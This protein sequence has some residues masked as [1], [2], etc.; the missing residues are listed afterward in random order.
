MKSALGLDEVQSL[1]WR[2][3]TA[4]AGVASGVAALQEEGALASEGLGW[5]VRP[6]ATLSPT[7][8]LDIYADMYFYRL[9]DCLAED[10]PTLAKWLGPARFHNLV[11]DYLLVHPSRH[12]SLRELGRE[13]PGF[14]ESR[15]LAPP[16]RAASDLAALEWARVDVF[17]ETDAEPLARQDLIERATAS[18]EH[19]RLAL[20][21][22]VRLIRLESA[23]LKLWR[24][25]ED[26]GELPAVG[27]TATGDPIPVCVWRRDFALC[28]RSLEPDEARCLGALAGEPLS[29]AAL[30]ELLL[31]GEGEGAEPASAGARFGALLELWTADGLL[32]SAGRESFRGYA[33]HA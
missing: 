20:V 11:T 21:P 33:S 8:R 5:L 9:R 23:V 16:F 6:S 13:L 26:D 1:L 29:L 32:R 28:H 2:L 15:P 7:E 3:L 17:D 4:P 12:P 18:P 31:D 19:F 10:F 27:D 30:G 14:L 25:L 22:A 24:G